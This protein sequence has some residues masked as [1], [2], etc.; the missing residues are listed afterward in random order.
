M[1]SHADM[2]DFVDWS[3]VECLNAQQSHGLANALKQACS[4]RITTA[5]MHRS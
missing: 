3:C 2:L 1:G 4:V 5:A